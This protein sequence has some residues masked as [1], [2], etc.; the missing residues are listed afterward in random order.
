MFPKEWAP[1]GNRHPFPEPYLAYPSGSPV[2]EPCLQVLLIKLPKRKMPCL[3]SPHLFIFQNPWYMSPLPGSLV[4]PLRREM[5]VP[6]A[7][8]ILS[9]GLF[10]KPFTSW[11]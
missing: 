10:T 8:M 5:P 7:S 9:G 3:Q 2:K 4:G 6:R 1:S 11:N